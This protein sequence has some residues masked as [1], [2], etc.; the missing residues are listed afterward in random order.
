MT[1]SNLIAEYWNAQPCN[2][3]H[4]TKPVGSKEYFEEVSAR[5]YF[6]EPH[7]HNFAN[8]K[9]WSGIKML[10]V[11]CGLGIDAAEFAKHGANYVG[12]D[13]S[14]NSIN[15]AKERFSTFNL[16]G[17]FHCIN[18]ADTEEMSKLGKFDFVYCWGTLHH[19]PDASSMLKNIYN[20]LND[21]GT[22]LFMVYAKNSWKHAMIQA[23]IDQFEAQDNCPYA[24]TF[25]PEDIQDLVGDKFEILSI[26]QDHCF[27]FNV[28]EYK[29]GNYKLEPWFEAMPDAVR[30]AVKTH[31]GW[32][33]LVSTRK[34]K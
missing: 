11:G 32:H 20:V 2:V 1:S 18:A 17:E 21:N 31:L 4:S 10:E 27:M 3:N 7:I 16:P 5:R 8:F 14:E 22:F 23:G 26:K 30:D 15:L 12:V 9:N 24:D 34:T 19:Y 6:V 29:Q 13:I 28:P 33:L 25:T